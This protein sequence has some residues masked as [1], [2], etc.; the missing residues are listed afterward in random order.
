MAHWSSQRIGVIALAVLRIAIFAALTTPAF[1]QTI[2]YEGCRD[3]NGVAAASVVKY[4]LQDVAAANVVQGRPVIFYNPRVLSWF[5]PQTRVFWYAHECGHLALGHNLKQTPPQAAE[6]EADCWA[7]RHLVDEMGYG[8]A[9]FAII[10]ADLAKLGGDWSHLPG[11]YRSID[12]SHCADSEPPAAAAGQKLEIR[13]ATWHGQGH[14]E[15]GIEVDG[16]NFG[17][18]DNEFDADSADGEL[19]PGSHHF[20]LTSVNAFDGYERQIA[21]DGSC[22]GVFRVIPGREHY[23]VTLRIAPGVLYCKIE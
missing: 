8:R 14:A 19:A 1:A 7:G 9:Q 15:F 17:S 11:T 12:I 3:I 4:D 10:L 2:V 18:V 23:S 16:E 13:F 22:S 6:R 20:Q 5:A 21:D